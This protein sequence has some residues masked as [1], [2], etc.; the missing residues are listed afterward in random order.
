[1]DL[2]TARDDQPFAEVLAAQ[3]QADAVLA[4]VTAATTGLQETCTAVQDSHEAW[5][6][7]QATTE[8]TKQTTTLA[9]VISAADERLAE[10]EGAVD[11]NIVRQALRDVLDAATAVEAATPAVT[12]ATQ[13]AQRDTALAHTDAARTAHDALDAAVQARTDRIAAE[14]ARP[15][16]TDPAPR[17]RT[18]G[19]WPRARRPG[20]ET[21]AP[22]APVIWPSGAVAARVT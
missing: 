10:T 8:A 4:E 11:D 16:R 18:D 20:H 6:L 12:V 1:M 7:Q 22:G 2:P 19:S 5:L 15:P 21:R 14:T 3:D 13:D 17:F 9:D